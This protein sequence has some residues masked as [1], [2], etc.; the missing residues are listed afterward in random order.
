M[1]SILKNTTFYFLLFL[2]NLLTIIDIEAQLSKKH[3]IPPLTYAEEGNANPENQYFYISTPSKKNVSFTIKQIGSNNDITGSVSSTDPQEILIGNDDSQLFVDSR[4]TSIVHNDK[5]YIIEANDVIY[6]SIRVLAGG[7]AQAGALVSKGNSAL[8]TTFRAGMFTNENPQSNYLNFISVMATE[9]NTLL[10]FD[11]LPAGILIKNYSGTLPIS[12]ISLNEGESYIVATNANDN[13]INRDALIGTLITSDKPIVVS[14]GSANGSFHNG[15]GRDYGID[16][17]VGID[18]IGDEYIFVKG[19]GNNNWENVLIVAHKDATTIRINGGGVSATINKGQYYLIEGEE[20]N[21]NGNM[22]VQTSN[23]VFE[24]QGIGAN[25]SEANQSLFFVPPLSCENRGKVD[26]I[27][28]IENIGNINFTGGIT[29]V[30]NKNATVS[31]NSLPLTNF[32]TSGPFNV[33]GNT[34]YVTYKVTNLTGNISIDSSDELYCAYFNENNAATS[35]S[36]YSGFPS[37]PEI[38]FETTVST[39]GNCIPNLTLQA[40]NTELFDSFKW[41]YYNN[42]TSTWDEKASDTNYKPLESEPGKY[43]LIGIINCNGATFESI[44]IPVS[45]CP[46]NH[47]GD[48][49]IDNLD[50]DLD[51]DGILNFDESKGNTTINFTNINSPILNF[52][53]GSQDISFISTNLNQTGTSSISGDLLSN[54]TSTVNSGTNSEL[55]YILNFNKASNIEFIE[56]TST[57]HTL[58][59][60]ETFILTVGPN[61]KNITLIDPDNILLVDTDYDDVFETSVP[62][63]SSAEIRFKFNPTPNGSTPY[64]FVANNVDQLIFKHLL[65]NT[66]DNS[67]FEGNLIITCFGID[68]DTDGII[69]AFDADSDNDGI[70]DIIEAQGIPV[71][72]LGTDANLDGLDDVFT[73]TVSPL[74]TDSDG[75]FDYLDLDSDNDGIFDTTESGHNLDTNLDGVIDNAIT[76]VGKN[77]LVDEL[78]TI[79]DSFILNYTVSNLDSDAIFSFLD[80]DSD[81]DDCPDV[82]EAG[83]T[84]TDNDS[85]IGKSPITVDNRGKVIGIT[86]GYTIPDP[87][88]NTSAPILL[89]TPFEDVVFCEASTSNITIDS[90]ADTFQWEVSIDGG[91][92]WTK[93]SDDTT[94]NGSTTHSLQITNLQLSFNDYK[95]RVYLERLGNACNDTSNE[96]NITVNPLPIVSNATIYQCIVAGD[97]NPTINLTTAEGNISS[98]PNITFEYFEDAAGSIPIPSPTSYPINVNILQSVY[99]KAIS[100]QGCDSN[101][102]QLILNIG[103]TPNNPFNALVAVECDDFRDTNG[104]DTPG[105]NDDTDTITNFFL[106]ENAI[107]TAINPPPLTQVFFYESISDRND[108]LFIP[109][110]SNYRNNPK[111]I[112]ITS[113][114]GGIEFPIYYKILSI[115]NKDCEGIGQFYLQV[116][117]VPKAYPAANFDL[118]DDDLSGN[119]TDGINSGINLRNRVA[120]IL[121]TTQTLADYDVTFHTSLIDANDP[122]SLGISNDTSFSNTPQAGFTTGDISEQIIFVR[123]QDKNTLCV[124]SPTSFKI[125]INPIPSISNTITPFPV[126][127]V[128]TLSDPDPRNRVAQ[129]I[130]LTSKN[131][132][133]LAGKTNHK[134]AYYLTQLDAENNIQINNT[135]DFQNITELTTFPTTTDFN[136][137]D[138]AIQTIFV[139]VFDQGGKKCTSIFSTFEL[140]IYPEPNIPLNISDYSDCD[141][142]TDIDADDA[143][144][145]IG[146]ITLKN[147]IPEIL[148]NYNPAEF[149]DFSVSFYTSSTD[150][151][152][153]DPTNAI[154]ENT[155]ENNSNGQPIFVRVENIKNTPIICVNTRLSF[156][157]NINPLPDFTVIGEENMEDPQIVCLNNT[158][159]TLEAENPLAT[160]TYQWTNEVGDVLGNDATLKVI[161]AGKYTV[162]ASD[163]SPIGCARERTIVVEE[164]NIATLEQSFITIIDEANNIGSEDTISMRIDT[165]NNNLGPGD[166][167]F[168]ISNNDTNERYP[169]SGYQEDPFFENLEGGIYTI[170]VNDKKGCSPDT[171]LQISV[172]QFPK[173][174]TPNG[175]GKNDTW[176]IKGANKIFY[177]NS[178]MNI[179]NRFGTLVAQIPIDS[180]GWDGTYNGK[181]LSSD[182]YW[183]SVQLI[184]ADTNKPPI[185]KKGHFSLLR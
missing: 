49:L 117:S 102:V 55:E 20:Y 16:Q 1:I 88:Y 76:T 124:S 149:A 110:I 21:S 182:D 47:D 174:F 176:K 168:A 22:Y 109:N 75:V 79:P 80:L 4:V 48:A 50:I 93:V 111:N 133:I 7:G 14:T 63:F 152:I 118:C 114:S 147:K 153:G 82:T 99:A 92:N 180:Q 26:N 119:T 57:T 77:G 175:D 70:T 86:D 116:K 184:P 137:D 181:T 165:T 159:L 29:I 13:I 67:T 19:N 139:K 38:N 148:A 170:T 45:L 6:V 60:N 74:D 85:I 107:V 100:N 62:N 44:E 123:V 172:I 18:K 185:L 161:A 52:I 59:P 121:G 35:G 54:F 91:S 126:C 132:E 68:S 28:K 104:N 115:I 30:T 166:Y 151:E 58:V 3:F 128:V 163:V 122:N 43:K 157:I 131:D 101:L 31:I 78:E 95:Y 96:I 69:D 106:D 81:G 24:Y 142:M 146:N 2:I 183:F 129:N 12:N 127:D 178:S 56:N 9:N 173:F 66:S 46:D 158:H 27:P 10:N 72:L 141:N 5:G 138:P 11:D 150:A 53:D 33:D 130:D 97:P 90:T 41:Y 120:D 25:N 34:N 154:N 15:G 83:F 162:T 17:I 171:E 65:N 179:F 40:A 134:V 89:N 112:D 144:G 71:S 167:Q 64:K 94:Y 125:I 36:F 135:T 42:T 160:Y 177:P 145:I 156:N 143:N 113:V 155:F 37:A 105:M 136:S 8:G 108:N 103:Q 39:I 23:P 98:T 169:F 32:S 73:S 61:T 51:N 140:V 164:S 84:D 87:D